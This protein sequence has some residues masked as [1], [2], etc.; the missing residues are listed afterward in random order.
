MVDACVHVSFFE[1]LIQLVQN[2]FGVQFIDETVSQW[3]LHVLQDDSFCDC[4]GTEVVR[5]F[6]LLCGA[7]LWRLLSGGDRFGFVIG[8]RDRQGGGAIDILH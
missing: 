5:Q 2:R 4:V 3:L 1:L 7:G 6:Q 8:G